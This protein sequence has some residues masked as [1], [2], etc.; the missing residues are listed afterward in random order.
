MVTKE[1]DI[2]MIRETKLD[3][4]FPASKYIIKNKIEAFL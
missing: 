3:D 2:L 4:S 1:I